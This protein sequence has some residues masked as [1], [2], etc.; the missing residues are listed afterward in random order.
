MA[1]PLCGGSPDMVLSS[2]GPGFRPGL[3]LV[4]LFFERLPRA[5]GRYHFCRDLDVG[6]A[7]RVPHSALCTL[8]R[9]EGSEAYELHLLPGCQGIAD[10]IHGRVQVNLGILFGTADL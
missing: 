4:D 3:G 5:E 2:P 6:P 8:F 1:F 7:L 10:G 9:F